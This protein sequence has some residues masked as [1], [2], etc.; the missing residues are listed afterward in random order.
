MWNAGG[1]AGWVHSRLVFM[2]VPAITPRS[3][4]SVSHRMKMN[5]SSAVNDS[6]EPN[7]E[8]EFHKVYVSG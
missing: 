2:Y 4:I 8:T 7:D 5:S 1:K 3:A 6:M